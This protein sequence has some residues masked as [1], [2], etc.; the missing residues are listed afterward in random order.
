MSAENRSEGDLV[1]WRHHFG[2]FEQF[3]KLHGTGP[4]TIARIIK[5][6]PVSGSILT[7]YEIEGVPNKQWDHSFFTDPT[8]VVVK[9]DPNIKAVSKTCTNPRCK[10]VHLTDKDCCGSCYWELG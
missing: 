3:S 8:N 7:Y 2:I 5:D 9:K 6:P 10:K 4:F 1:V